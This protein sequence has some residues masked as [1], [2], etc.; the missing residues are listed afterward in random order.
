MTSVV[1]AEVSEAISPARSTAS[2]PPLGADNVAHL[3]RRPARVPRPVP[4]RRPG[5]TTRPRRSS[6]P[7]TVEEIQEI[8]RDRQRAQGPAVD[9]RHRAQQRLRRAGAARERLGDRQPAQHEPRARDQRGARLRRRR[10]GRALVRPLRGDQ[11]GRA[12]ADALDRRPRLGQRRS[13]TRSTTA[14]PTCPTAS[15]WRRSAGWRSCSRT[16]R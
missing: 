15:T 10:A 11:G 3:R 4:V 9:A 7:T 13:A 2:P 12:Q 14:S 5:T 6:C 8:V 16:A 1:S